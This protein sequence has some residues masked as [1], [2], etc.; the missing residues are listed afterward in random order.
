MTNR[1]CNSQGIGNRKVLEM[2]KQTEMDISK[3]VK[4]IHSS[5]TSY[6]E[7]SLSSEEFQGYVD[8]LEQAWKLIRRNL[9]IYAEILSR[10]E[11]G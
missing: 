5:L 2:S 4:I 7:E 11:R 6:T 9:S 10:N 1:V 3:A 8:K